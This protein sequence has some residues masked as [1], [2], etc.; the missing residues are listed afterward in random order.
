LSTRPER[1][2]LSL[3][4]YEEAIAG[5]V[6]RWAQEVIEQERCDER[7]DNRAQGFGSGLLR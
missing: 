5:E 3:E 2:P 6:V 1:F 7:S 4:D